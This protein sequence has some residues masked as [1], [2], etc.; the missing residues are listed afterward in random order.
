MMPR[1]GRNLVLQNLQVLLRPGEKKL[2][3]QPFPSSA[4]LLWTQPGPAFA[5]LCPH[6]PQFALVFL[7]MAERA[8]VWTSVPDSD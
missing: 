3:L 5:C 4:A 8:F 7:S 1:G 6:V 2:V